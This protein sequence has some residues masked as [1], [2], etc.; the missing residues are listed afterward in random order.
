MSEFLLT[1]SI[2][3]TG[4]CHALS[5]RPDRDE[6]VLFERLNLPQREFLPLVFQNNGEFLQK[7]NFLFNGISCTLELELSDF[8]SMRNRHSSVPLSILAP[9]L[10]WF[11]TL[12]NVSYTHKRFYALHNKT[13]NALGLPREQNKRLDQSYERKESQIERCVFYISAF[14]CIHMNGLHFYK[15]THYYW[16][17]SPPAAKY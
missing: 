5:L 12:N 1:F 4:L 6:Q 14:T 15:R 8:E 17:C 13:S 16:S 9:G 2:P 3:F 7:T 10:V 11:Y